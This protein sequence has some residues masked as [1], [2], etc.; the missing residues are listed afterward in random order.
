VGHLPDLFVQ[1]HTRQEV[2]YASLDVGMKL[3]VEWHCG[4]DEYHHDAAGSCQRGEA[5]LRLR[6]TVLA[7]TLFLS[8][9]PR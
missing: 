4:E 7:Q 2:I 3:V 9:F 5:A 1:R 8:R 6:R